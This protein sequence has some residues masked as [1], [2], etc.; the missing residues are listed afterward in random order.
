MYPLINA[1][2]FQAGWWAC[3]AGVGHGLE[4]Q[5]LVFCLVLTAA[6]LYFVDN[7]TEELKLAALSVALGVVADSL[8]Q[9]LSVISFY[10]WALGPLSPFWLWSLW[11]LFALTLNASLSFLKRQPLFISAIA[12]ITFGPLTYVAGARLG[13]AALDTTALHLF[14]IALVWMIALPTMVF[15]ARRTAK[16]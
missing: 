8:L 7:A 3:I 14:A 12:G 15:M 13:A 6:H 9:Y 2:G 16:D 4:I 5:A 1:I 11:L 10:G